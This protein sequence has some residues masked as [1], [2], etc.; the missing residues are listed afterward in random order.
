M[1]S[2]KPS[3]VAE[4]LET[5]YA[6]DPGLRMFLGFASLQSTNLVASM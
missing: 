6:A 3:M 5:V 2:A 1:G 4:L